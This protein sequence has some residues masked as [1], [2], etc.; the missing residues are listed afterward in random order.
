MRLL[1]GHVAAVCMAAILMFATA[2]AA[3][4]TPP[5]PPAEAQTAAPTAPPATAAET[6]PENDQNEVICKKLEAETGTRLGKRKECRTRR[7][8][9]EIAEEAKRNLEESRTKN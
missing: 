5:P 7:E 4:E 6:A 2:S 8:W 3:E 1:G 9:D